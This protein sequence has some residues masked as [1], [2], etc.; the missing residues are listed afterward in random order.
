MATRRNFLQRAFG[1]DA[2]LALGVH[3]PRVALAQTLRSQRERNKDVKLNF[4]DA[5]GLLLQ[6]GFLQVLRGLPASQLSMRQ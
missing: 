4:G 2:G 3:H 5:L 6:L 1:A